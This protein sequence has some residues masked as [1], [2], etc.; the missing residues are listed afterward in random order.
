MNR[1]YFVALTDYT[2]WVNKTIIHWLDQISD[3]QWNQL[4]VSSFPSIRQTVVH[5]VSA[6][7]VW[8][9]FWRKVPDPVFLSIEFTGTKQELIETWKNVSINLEQFIRHYPE[10]NYRQVITFRVRNEE[11][12]MEF[13]Q[14]FAHFSNHATYHRG[15]LVTLLRQAGFTGFLNTDLATYFRIHET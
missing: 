14:T 8:V 5:L 3:Q 13:W 7:K 10:E 11:W 6:E 12:Q 9:D 2:L 1:T 4:I 15:Q